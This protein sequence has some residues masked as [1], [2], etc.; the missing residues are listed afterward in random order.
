LASLPEGETKIVVWVAADAPGMAA[1]AP[2]PITVIA[3]VPRTYLR[4]RVI[5][6]TSTGQLGPGSGA[7]PQPVGYA[8]VTSTASY[9]IGGPSS[10]S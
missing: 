10:Y 6:L 8:V 4:A 5:P 7:G 2:K 3:I 9:V 1:A